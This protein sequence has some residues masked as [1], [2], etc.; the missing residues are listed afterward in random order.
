M[1]IIYCWVFTMALRLV[2]QVVSFQRLMVLFGRFLT[3]S[4]LLGCPGWFAE[5]HTWR[6]L[7]GARLLL[8]LNGFQYVIITTLH[9]RWFLPVLWWRCRIIV[10]QALF[11]HFSLWTVRN[12]SIISLLTQSSLILTN[13][14]KRFDR[15]KVLIQLILPYRAVN[16]PHVIDVMACIRSYLFGV[17]NSICHKFWGYCTLSSS[18]RAILNIDGPMP[19][20]WPVSRPIILG[21]YGLW[22]HFLSLN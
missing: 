19:H 4:S 22:H 20:I 3:F 17:K 18:P 14:R 12:L 6:V 2:H 21:I 16:I 10:G 9:P 13:L 8:H 1:V 5:E 11:I 7:A 15:L